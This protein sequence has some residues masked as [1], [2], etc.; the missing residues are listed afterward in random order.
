MITVEATIDEH[1]GVHLLE[2]L[3]LPAARRA[4]VTILD[5]PPAQRQ[6]TDSLGEAAKQAR[7]I[8]IQVARRDTNITYGTLVEKIQAVKFDLEDDESRYELS[9]LIGNM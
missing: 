2:A 6:E 3:V 5:E 8:L 7:D 9:G 1:G 4:L